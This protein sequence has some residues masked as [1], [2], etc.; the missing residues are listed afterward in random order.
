MSDKSSILKAFNNHFF[1]FLDDIIGIFPENNDIREARVTFETFKRGNPTLIIK[2]WFQYVYTPY[3]TAIL[4]GDIT[5]F[6]EKDYSEDLT[7]IA[8]S[9]SVMN[10]IDKIRA[11]IKNM[12]DFNKEH[13]AKYIQNLSKLAEVYNNLTK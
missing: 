8:N 3:S 4:S 10:I 12:S 7:M 13:C 9:K 2:V 5:F 6:T 1:E 11:P